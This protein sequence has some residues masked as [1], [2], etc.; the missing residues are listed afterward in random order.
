MNPK[1]FNICIEYDDHPEDVVDKINSALQEFN[2][3]LEDDDENHEG[4]VLYRIVEK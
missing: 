4:Y 2:L 3:R 1:K